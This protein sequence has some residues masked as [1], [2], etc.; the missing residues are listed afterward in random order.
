MGICLAR[1]FYDKFHLFYFEGPI[2]MALIISAISILIYNKK[3]K[4]TPGDILLSMSIVDL[5]QNAIF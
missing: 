1:Y 3:Y 4:N 5:I 2:V